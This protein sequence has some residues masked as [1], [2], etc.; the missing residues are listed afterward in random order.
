[1]T[2]FIEVADWLSQAVGVNCSYKA[3]G[4]NNRL[5]LG[6]G[7]GSPAPLRG[8]PDRLKYE[9]KIG[10]YNSPWRIVSGGVI[11]CGSADSRDQKTIDDMLQKINIGAFVGIEMI[12]KFDIRVNF[13]GDLYVDFMCAANLDDQ[14]FHILG[15][16]SS[17]TYDFRNGWELREKIPPVR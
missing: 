7:K 2:E 10:T 4:S 16:D 3:I 5:S 12:S 15:T 1:M 14:M 8:L 9:W 13:D 6:L 17:A 11:L